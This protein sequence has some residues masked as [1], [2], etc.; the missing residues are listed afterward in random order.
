M[1]IKLSKY[2]YS[3]TTTKGLQLINSLI[4][5]TLIINHY[6]EYKL[7]N[8]CIKIPANT[9]SSAEYG[10]YYKFKARNSY[11]IASKKNEKFEI[12]RQ[13][14]CMYRN[15][16]ITYENIRVEIADARVAVELKI[17]IWKD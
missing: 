6:R 15:F 11:C 12:D 3:I 1:I 13:Y 4:A 17:P 14:C 2:R 8:T 7:V 5:G 9:N 10:Y 16:K